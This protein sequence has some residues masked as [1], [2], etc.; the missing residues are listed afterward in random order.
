MTIIHD[1][2]T[3]FE[4]HQV[5][6]NRKCSAMF[7]RVQSCSIMFNRV[8]SCSVFC[9]YLDER[10]GVKHEVGAGLEVSQGAQ[11]VCL[12]QQD[13]LVPLEYGQG[14]PEENLRALEEE[15]VPDPQLGLKH[16]NNCCMRQ[17]SWECFV[18][19]VWEET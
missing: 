8:Q 16:P 4:L 1:W 18:S 3:M 13:R 12:L 14:E 6:F 19:T 7:N 2:A 15:A 9:G 10:V 5:L 11:H 17:G